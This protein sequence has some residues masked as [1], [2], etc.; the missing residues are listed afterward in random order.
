MPGDRWQKLANLR[1]LY[2]YMWAH[3]GKKL[4]FMGG[5][6]AQEAEWSHERS[7][8]WHLLE[9]RENAGV[10]ALVRA[11]NSVYRETPALWEVDFDPR[12]FWW[13]EPNDAEA[14]VVAFCRAGEDPVGDVLACVCNL[15]PVVREGY[16]LGLPQPGRWVE[17]LNTDSSFFG[18]TNAGNLGG[19]EAEAVGWA[20]QPFSAAVT[21]PP[22][23]VLWLVRD[24]QTRGAGRP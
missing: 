15:S 16:R 21:L 3:P 1:C 8:D 23:S 18:G 7:L 2:A 5:E 4:L 10:Q 22:L 24:A 19:V 11:L 17:A 12:G 6:L 13:L 14:N 9:N 20:G